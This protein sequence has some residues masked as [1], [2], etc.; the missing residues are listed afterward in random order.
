MRVMANIKTGAFVTLKN[1]IIHY[2]EWDT[3]C[4]V[5]ECV[6]HQWERMGGQW[7]KLSILN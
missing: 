3:D 5:L 7:Y 1:G 4:V 2:G 6:G